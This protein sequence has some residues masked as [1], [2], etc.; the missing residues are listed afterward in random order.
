MTNNHETT[1]RD[2]AINITN[3][4]IQLGYVPD[5]TDTYDE[6][7]FEVQDAIVDV[8]E[9]LIPEGTFEGGEDTNQLV[10]GT[11]YA[12]KCDFTGEGMNEGWCF[13]DG[14]MYAKYEKDAIDYAKK[15]GYDGLQDAFD[16]EA[17][18]WTE[19]E[20]GYDDQYIVVDGKLIEIQ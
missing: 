6:S 2:I 15:I 13:G 20:C 9:L 19:W 1:L 18:Y 11:K 14:E 16:E 4:L 10:E 17:V 5:C 12:R 3:K 7:E 8:L